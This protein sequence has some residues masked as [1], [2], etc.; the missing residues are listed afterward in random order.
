MLTRHWSGG[1]SKEVEHGV[2][3]DENAALQQD[4]ETIAIEC[5]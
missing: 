5:G 3:L 4:H 2:S 1:A